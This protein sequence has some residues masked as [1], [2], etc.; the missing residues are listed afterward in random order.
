ML[1]NSILAFIVFL[2]MPA[3]SSL[4]AQADSIAATDSTGF[5]ILNVNSNVEKAE[6]FLDSASIGFTP[7]T[8]FKVKSG[9]YEL[10]L[11]NPKRLGDWQNENLVEKVTLNVDT[12]VTANFP[13]F[14]QFNSLPFDA[15]VIRNDTIL[16]STPLRYM[17]EYLM[18][19]M[20]TFRKENYRDLLFDMNSYDPVSGA[21]VTLKLNDNAVEDIDVIKN[22]GTQFKTRRNLPLIL[23]LAASSIT[24]G[25]FAYDYKTKANELY[26]EYTVT[27][28]KQK[29]DDSRQN[30]TYFAIALVLM[31]AA[32]GGLVYFLFFD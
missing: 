9:K 22:K 10:K 14:Y 31:Q 15:S 20:V 28:D 2:M 18:K 11:L 3:Y 25:Y 30:D 4:R 17:S 29:L 12:T 13:Y 16:G 7:V 5:I 32:I 27:G 8:G 21:N 1:R 19:G 24:A 26:T 23:G 6:V